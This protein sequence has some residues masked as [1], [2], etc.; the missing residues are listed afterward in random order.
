[1]KGGL[2]ARTQ[3]LRVLDERASEAGA[4][5]KDTKLSYQAVIHHLHLLEADGTV[6][7]SGKK[8]FSW[9]LTGLGQRRLS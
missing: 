8:P 4:M 3:I 6:R 5:A 9:S 1:V 2:K 7:R